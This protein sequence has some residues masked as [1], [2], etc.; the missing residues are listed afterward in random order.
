MHGAPSVVIKGQ[1]EAALREGCIFAAIFSKAWN[2][3]VGAA[4]AYWV[5][6]SQVSRRPPSG[7]FLPRGAFMVRGKRNYVH[8]IALEA[9]VG[10]IFY[11]D[12]RLVMCGPVPS[13]KALC[14]RYVII[15]PGSIKKSTLA[16][17]LAGVFS[18]TADEIM[19]ILPPGNA[20]IKEARGIDES[21]LR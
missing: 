7:E 2:A 17:K 14:E 6:P 1:S 20:D 10:E 19:K 16:K 8:N 9:G 12:T 11:E 21:I 4:S 13:V 5:L 18:A 15:I 3:G